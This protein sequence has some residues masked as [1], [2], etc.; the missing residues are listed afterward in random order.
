MPDVSGEHAAGK[1]LALVIGVDQTRSSILPALKHAVTDAQ[2]VAD[3]LVQRCQ[4]SLHVPP[5][6]GEQATSANIKRTVLELVRQRSADDFLL[7]YFS[8]HG[9]QAYDELRQEIRHT[10]LG[11]ADFKE[12]EVEEDPMTMH[13]SLHW[14]RERLFEKTNAGRV[15][16]ILDCC[17]GED[18]RTGSDH[19]LDE[20]RRQLQHYFE[21]PGAEVKKR[22]AGLYAALA[23][24]GYD[25]TAGE[26]DGHGMMTKLLLKVLR[27]EE[28][29]VVG[30]QG[31]MTLNRLLDY[32]NTEMPG[33]YKPV[34]SYT[35]S[36]GQEC[37]LVTYPE[38]ARKSSRALVADCP[39]SY[40]PF[41]RNNLFQPRPGEFEDLEKM[42][43]PSGTARQ[44]VRVG[45]VGVTGMGG[46]GKTQLAIEFAYRYQERFPGG[47]FWMAA[48][49]HTL[50]DWQRHFAE[51]ASNADYLP[52]DDDL[53]H[54]ENERRRARHLCRYLAQHAD[55]L[56]ILDNV[57]EP[58]LVTSALPALAGSDVRCAILYTSRVTS[59][60]HDVRLHH[61]EHLP[62]DAALRLLLETTR[63]QTWAAIAAG[64]ESAETRA[65]RGV[66]ERVGYLPLALVHLRGRLAQDEQATLVRMDQALR[67]GKLASLKQVLFET[68][69]WSW[70]RV[71]DEVARRLFLLSC[72]FPEATPISLWLL[73]LAAGLGENAESF[74]PL[75]EACLQLQAA[76]LF[77]R[78]SGEQVRLHPLVREFGRRLV[79]EDGD[80]GETL[81]KEA[82]E[83]LTSEFE[84][85][86]KLERR[87]R[88]AGYWGCLEQV[89]SA[90]EY[91]ELL[92]TEKAERLEQVERWLDRESYVL[93][94]G[95]WWP[96][97]LPGL[98]YQQLSNRALE[99]GTPLPAG[100][101]PACWL[102]QTGQVGAE[103]RSLLRIYAGHTGRVRSVAFAP[104]GSRVLTGSGDSTAR[105]WETASGK[106][107]ATLADH[108]DSVKSVAISPDGS[109]VLTGSRDGTAQLWETASGKL[110]TT[111]AGHTGGVKSVAFAPDGSRVLT[112]SYDG[113]ARLWETA[114]GKL[115]ATLA[116]HTSRVRSVAFAPDG[117]RVLTGSDD[118]TARLWETTSSKLLVT[119]VGHT[120]WVRSV[121]FSPDGSRV[122]TGSYDGTARLWETASGK[123]L[124][125]LAGHTSRV[126]SVAFAP[127]GGRVLT[128]S[129]D[130]TA[131]LWETAS[132][133]LLATVVGH[134]GG[135]K[136]VA[137]SPDGSRMLTGS[138]DST[139]RLWETASGKLLA[140]LAGHTGRVGSVTFSPDGSRVLTGSDD[141]TAR[142]WET[143][144][145][146]LLATE[147]GHRDWVGSV[148][149]S[150]NGSRVLTGS[151]D[152]TAR[153]WETASGKLLAT[154][155][156]HSSG[157]GSVA[158]SPDGSRVLTGSDDSTARLWETTSS[159]LLATLA[160]HTGGVKSVAFSPDGSRV[161][162]GS[163]DGRARLWETTSSKLLATVAGHSSGVESVAFAPDGSRVLTGSGD[164]TARLWE[165]ASGKLLAT[166]AGHRGG[167]GSIAFSPDGSR[168]LTGSRNGTARVW[169]MASGRLLATLAG[170]AGVVGSVTFAPDGHLVMTCDQHGRVLLWRASGADM[171]SLLG[172]YVATYEVGTV[173]WQD[174]THV[175]VA[176]KGGP[177]FRPHFYQLKLEGM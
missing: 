173:Y 49:E 88:R 40:L 11:S 124:A 171:G 65:A 79:A 101:V 1:R 111:L 19:T 135:V 165:M 9:Q 159:K 48:T 6:L 142:L 143:T 131:R 123:L 61:V 129:D 170:H 56:L 91:A 105:L 39:T 168:V 55:A 83:Q 21:I 90:R 151:D 33:E 18:I 47:I 17:Y 68:F 117:S 150:P 5:L 27:G 7:L 110:L 158:F 77:E 112:G 156:G 80:T 84:D 2:D 30:P 35:N 113:T 115:L 15:L 69:R 20:L 57:E 148:A 50:F 106:L 42:L 95:R 118:S 4:F 96:Q 24:A 29:A 73:G 16:V 104:D 144:S 8:G 167:V 34:I 45:L 127:D 28:P 12:E 155:A 114:S 46:I 128:G 136:S 120:E 154:L 76:N 164:S 82:G 169:E 153:L 86:N 138:D 160:D 62:P 70:E 81:L 44:P 175:I 99:V 89:R 25:K 119:L 108:T 66:C 59:A 71:H 152:S 140:T 100:E 23:A 172:M 132:G 149:F 163:G 64:Q 43:L 122:L 109:R 139:A 72:S 37:V 32:I 41:M 103:D 166:L 78:L 51:L 146:K 174:N 98:F 26:A 53:S 134:T 116:G 137:F 162:T 125:T 121:A 85:L 107:L 126:R 97:V 157:V 94:D 93:A 54:P 36:S 74:E 130:S 145:S 92:L 31:Q 176:D 14:L 38:L 22:R 10:Y 60:L 161:L 67:Q 58:E 87:A 75:G 13:V 3:V 177:H 63:P 52:A 102:R 141:S 133:K 147:V